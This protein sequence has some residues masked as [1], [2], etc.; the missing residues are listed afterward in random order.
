V[1]SALSRQS[2]TQLSDVA[3]NSIQ[4]SERHLRLR[5]VID[6]LSR[7]R[8]DVIDQPECLSVLICKSAHVP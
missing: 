7:N 6:R 1:Q 8:V 3:L 2:W 5:H 4:G